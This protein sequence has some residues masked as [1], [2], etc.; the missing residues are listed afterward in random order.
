MT[1][2]NPKLSLG[3]ARRRAGLC[4]LALALAAC[5]L[6]K[7][8]I[9]GLEGPSEL[10]ISFLMTA[11]PDIVTADGIS[12]ASIQ[13]LVRNPAG[14]PISGQGV[15]FSIAD[16]SGNFA[17]IG[18]LSSTTATSGSNGIAQ[19]IYRVPARTDA[20]ANRF[21]EVA[22]RPISGDA[23]GQLYRTVTIELRRAEPRLFPENPRNCAGPNPRGCPFANFTIE[24]PFNGRQFLFQTT[25]TDTADETGRVGFIVRYEWDYGDGSPRDDKPD[26]SHFYALS[27]VYT[28]TH[29]VT[30]DN[31]AEAVATKTVVVP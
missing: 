11:T 14:Q 29:R 19:V 6:D 17:D 30:D 12:T 5:G 1:A 9:P 2:T 8:S 25:S 28:V 26:T 18:T 20:T 10:S 16:G 21:V 27:G 24:G 4:A 31:G 7:Q 13:V 23:R 15:T 22:A 3:P